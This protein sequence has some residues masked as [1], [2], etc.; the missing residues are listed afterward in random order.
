MMRHLDREHAARV[1]SAIEDAL[2]YDGPETVWTPDTLDEIATI[3]RGAGYGP[4]A[5]KTDDG[6]RP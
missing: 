3:M 6:D 5:E 4:G 1:L 2:W